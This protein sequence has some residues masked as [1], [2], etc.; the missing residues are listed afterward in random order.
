MNTL[1][2]KYGSDERFL[3][4]WGISMPKLQLLSQAVSRMTFPVPGADPATVDAFE[5]PY[6]GLCSVYMDRVSGGGG[7]SGGTLI[8]QG[9]RSDIEGMADPARPALNFVLSDPWWD[10]EQVIFQHF[11]Q[12]VTSISSGVP[13]Y[14]T[15][16]FSQ[17]N[18]FQDISAGPGAPWTTLSTDRQ[19]AQIVTFANGSGANVQLGACD[20]A[21]NLPVFPV[22]NITCAAAVLH[23]LSL[24]PN[25]VTFFDYSTSPPTLHIRQRPN[26]TAVTMPFGNGPTTDG[27]PMHK[28]SRLR[29]LSNLQ[30]S[31]VVLQYRKNFNYNGGQSTNLLI[32]SYPV[33]SNGRS[34]GAIVAAVDLRG[35][36]LNTVSGVVTST[37]ID[38]TTPAFWQNYKCDLAD[39]SI[40]GL[41]V[42]SDSAHP[43]KVTDSSGTDLT[44]TWAANWPNAIS[45]NDSTGLAPWMPIQVK[46]VTISGW[47]S[48]TQKNTLGS[49][50]GSASVALHKPEAHPVSVRLKITN[51]PAGS[52]PYSTVAQYDPGETAPGWNFATSDF[53]TPGSLT[54]DGKGG[55]AYLI[56]SSMQQLQ[57]E[58]THSIVQESIT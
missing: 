35:G 7:F 27:S 26:C 23:C 50:S 37:A 51:S 57:Y 40:T 52:Q 18:L 3:A 2:L 33:A 39:A 41:T 55:V 19:I 45:T 56:W 25:A 22:K 47:V 42:L 49:G 36:V 46:D 21:W 53:R 11:W 8:F 20:P 15:Q 24:V 16:Y 14:G 31:Q 54:N 5:I 12:V 28:S 29:P 6:K 48:Y 58:G 10:L 34:L 9:R 4:D 17:L 43:I 44:S 30:A 13:T 32:D 38:P 1:T